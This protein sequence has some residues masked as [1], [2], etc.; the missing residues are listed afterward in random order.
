M[1]DQL[2]GSRAE[3]FHLCECHV[4][5]AFAFSLI[6]WGMEALFSFAELQGHSLN[7]SM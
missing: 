2:A 6:G 1:L 7:M 4:V 5:D 3:G